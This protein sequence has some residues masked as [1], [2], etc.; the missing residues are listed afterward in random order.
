MHVLFDLDGTLTDPAR[1]IVAC[2][3]G[4]LRGMGAEVP[5]ELTRYIG[6]PLRDTMRQLLGTSDPQRVEEAMVLFRARYATV[7]LFENDPY[8]QVTSTLALLRDGGL[9]LR[10]V[11]SKPRVYAERI[12]V[13][14]GMRE[15]FEQVHGCELDGTRENKVDLMR[16]VVQTDRL[17][18][19]RTVMV[20]DRRQDVEAAQRHGI[21]A[22]G[23]LW[24][25]GS[26]EELTEAGADMLVERVD[27]LPCAVAGLLGRT[28]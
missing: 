10:I 22:I 26:R 3:E 8:P 5:G 27:D 6:P 23:V 25:Y 18:P 7:G 12:A 20:G 2:L 13:H 16:H 1:G 14:F 9:A 17:E 11:T 28:A 24:G 4:A 19:Q 21:A 15:L